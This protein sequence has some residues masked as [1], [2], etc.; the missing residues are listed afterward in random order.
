MTPESLFYLPCQAQ[1][2][3][4]SFFID[5]NEPPREILD[6]ELWISNSFIPYQ[7]P[8][9]QTPLPENENRLVDNDIVSTATAEWRDSKK[10]P[11]EGNTRFFRYAL[12][13]RRAGLSLTE[14][15]AKLNEEVRHGRSPNDR[16][17]QIRSIMET[18]G[19]PPRSTG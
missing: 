2:P 6:A 16:Q 18:L 8:C 3:S 13:L 17:R 7:P 14:I 5:Y 19:K 4:Q 11:G 1:D 15:Q 12:E 9:E 10:H